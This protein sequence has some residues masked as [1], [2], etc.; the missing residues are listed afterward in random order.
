MERHIR[1]PELE[2]LT[3]R[4]EQL[5]C[6]CAPASKEES[7][8]NSTIFQH[9]LFFEA[10]TLCSNSHVKTNVLLKQGFIFS[11]TKDVLGEAL[12]SLVMQLIEDISAVPTPLSMFFRAAQDR[13]LEKPMHSPH[14]SV[15]LKAG[16]ILVY[17]GEK[18]V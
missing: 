12:Y 5:P 15:A 9:A 1:G 17:W 11:A 13:I 14:N 2:P 4:L 6:G 16:A 10:A 3:A 8:E 7:P 18:N